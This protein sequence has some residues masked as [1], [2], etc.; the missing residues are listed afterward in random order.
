MNWYPWDHPNLVVDPRLSNGIP[1]GLALFAPPAQPLRPLRAVVD[2]EV[3]ERRNSDPRVKYLLELLAV[4]PTEAMLYRWDRPPPGADIS[5]AVESGVTAT[6]GWVSTEWIEQDT[7][8]QIRHWRGGIP[9]AT[10]IKWN[11][12][13]MRANALARR[14]PKNEAERTQL[15]ADARALAIAASIRADLYITDRQPLVRTDSNEW[16]WLSMLST[17]DAIPMVGLYLR[18][19]NRFVKYWA[20]ALGAIKAPSSEGVRAESEFYW[21]AAQLFVPAAARGPSS[22]RLQMQD[23]LQSQQ[24]THRSFDDA[25]VWRI[26]QALQARDRLLAILAV[27]P[28]DALPADRA[29]T[30]LELIL[31]WFMAALDVTARSVHLRC[32]LPRGEYTAAWQREEWREKLKQKEPTRAEFFDEGTDANSVLTVIQRLRNSIHGASAISAQGLTLIVGVNA[33]QTFIRIPPPDLD[34]ILAKIAA[35]GGHEDWGVVRPLPDDE[36]MIHPG[37][38]VERLFPLATAAI[39]GTLEGDPDLYRRAAPWGGPYELQVSEKRILWQFGFQE[40]D[41]PE[42]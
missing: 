27:A 37:R 26:Q 31:M 20:P 25:V 21:Q 8:M 29:A 24:Q 33:M 6:Q 15:L 5:I 1:A 18:C 16:S 22:H 38:F 9:V 28:R 42:R 7:T 36:L 2:A 34:A 3:L 32:R 35:L 41:V 39:N 19:Q 10:K 14:E 11:E 23:H 17:H 40:G 13:E 12:I 30:E 4:P